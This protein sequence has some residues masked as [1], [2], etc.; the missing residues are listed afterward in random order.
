MDIE[1]G[2]AI[3]MTANRESYARAEDADGAAPGNSKGGFCEPPGSSS[4]A[5]SAFGSVRAEKPFSKNSFRGNNSLALAP[6][7]L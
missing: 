1:G 7:I 5:D 4:R 3:Q 6:V 2:P